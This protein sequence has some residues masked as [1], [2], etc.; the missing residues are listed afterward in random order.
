MQYCVV[1]F[2]KVHYTNDTRD[3]QYALSFMQIYQATSVPTFVDTGCRIWQ[4]YCLTIGYIYFTGT[5]MCTVSGS[6]RIVCSVGCP[7]VPSF[8]CRCCD[9]LLS[10]RRA[11]N[12]DRLLR[13][14]LSSSSGG[15]G[16]MRP[17]PRWQLAYIIYAV[18]KWHCYGRH[19]DR[20]CMQ[21][22]LS[23]FPA[24]SRPACTLHVSTD[25]TAW[26][27]CTGI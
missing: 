18:N 13:A 24:Y 6:A 21:L 20:P 3:G 9:S 27:A 22:V 11:G 2:C 7:S 23:H 15:G 26:S 19:H 4:S 5:H 16:R 10:A 12:V 25:S 1:H 14:A 17:A 8:S